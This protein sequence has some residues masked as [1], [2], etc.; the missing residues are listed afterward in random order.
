LYY[1]FLLFTIQSLVQ[2]IFQ[3]AR[4]SNPSIIFFDEID[5]IVGK[6]SLGEGNNGIRNGYSVQ[7]CV[8]SM[9]L[10][11]MDGIEIAT[12]ILVVVS[13]TENYNFTH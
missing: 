7:E 10:N 5:A 1:L 11:E 3:R 6:R 4:A 2:S 12:S 8:L 9:L 13:Y